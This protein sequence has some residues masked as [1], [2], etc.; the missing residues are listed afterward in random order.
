[1][2]NNC[3]DNGLKQYLAALVVHQDNFLHFIN[4]LTSLIY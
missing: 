3:V 1:M 2:A 4:T